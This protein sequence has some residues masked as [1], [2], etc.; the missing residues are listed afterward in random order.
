MVL[1][2]SV[3]GNGWLDTQMAAFCVVCLLWPASA[4]VVKRLHDRNRRGWWGLLLVVGWML[5]AGNWS[6]FD[7]LWQWT[8]G[9]FLPTVIFIAMLLDLGLFRGTVGD[10]RF[11]AMALPVR[12]P[13]MTHQ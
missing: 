4:V 7:S 9:R 5:L 11:G 13:M 12:Y 3:A 1:L 8:L 10:N 2:F 6:Q